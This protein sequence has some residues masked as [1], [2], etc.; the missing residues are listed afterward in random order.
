MHDPRLVISLKE[1]AREKSQEA[2]LVPSRPLRIPRP[3][4]ALPRKKI[5]LVLGVVA[6]LAMAVAAYRWWNVDEESPSE[7]AVQ[8][9]AADTATAASSE[10]VIARIA[11]LIELPEGETPTTAVVSDLSKLA[12]QPFFARAK[13]GYVVLLY[14][15]ARK[16]FLY[17]PVA[18]KIIEAASISQ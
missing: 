5:A 14:P 7:V 9:Q 12:G 15:N 8:T 6:V 17:D 1:P 4:R 16:A 3:R 10:D 18:D 13:E 2:P 11:R